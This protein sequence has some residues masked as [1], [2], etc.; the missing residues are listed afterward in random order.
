M[1]HHHSPVVVT[2][3]GNQNS[4]SERWVGKSINSSSSKPPQ[5]SPRSKITKTQEFLSHSCQKSTHWKAQ[6]CFFLPCLNITWKVLV[7]LQEHIQHCWKIQT[8]PLSKANHLRL[9]I[10]LLVKPCWN[11]FFWLLSTVVL[12]FFEH[13]FATSFLAT[14]NGHYL[15]LTKPDLAGKSLLSSLHWKLMHNSQHSLLLEL[16][17]YICHYSQI[18]PGFLEP[19]SVLMRLGKQGSQFLT[20]HMHAD[21]LALLSAFFSVKFGHRESL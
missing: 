16:S 20:I 3:P 11:F 19:A 12:L 4:N 14:L 8:F 5:P 10:V 6:V 9:Q 18:L 1:A 2:L 13:R 15:K 17:Y 21:P 7:R